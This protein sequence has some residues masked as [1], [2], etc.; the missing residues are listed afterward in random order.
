MVDRG[1]YAWFYMVIISVAPEHARA[2]KMPIRSQ[3]L[4]L[5]HAWC[6]NLNFWTCLSPLDAR[7]YNTRCK[8]AFENRH[9]L[10]K[11]VH[12]QANTREKPQSCRIFLMLNQ[13]C[14]SPMFDFQPCWSLLSTGI[15][16]F[17]QAWA[18]SILDFFI[19]AA[20]LLVIMIV[21]NTCFSVFLKV[22]ISSKKIIFVIN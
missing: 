4:M 21:G 13:A 10:A 5:T 22:Q 16:I 2:W 7:F 18:R 20:T 11:I 19:V 6:S 8:L 9:I 14:S 15:F 17:E 12:F 1:E 3:F